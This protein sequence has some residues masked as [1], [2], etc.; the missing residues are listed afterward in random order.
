[1]NSKNSI[2]S[3][4]NDNIKNLAREILDMDSLKFQLQGFAYSFNIEAY[5]IRSFKLKKWF[6]K[7][8]SSFKLHE[9]RKSDICGRFWLFEKFSKNASMC[10]LWLKLKFWDPRTTLESIPHHWEAYKTNLGD[11]NFCF[12]KIFF[13]NFVSFSKQFLSVFEGFCWCKIEKFNFFKK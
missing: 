7:H 5:K 4:S 9:A 1:M 10:H 11:S 6:F 3:K 12:K 2:F 8:Q 13:Q